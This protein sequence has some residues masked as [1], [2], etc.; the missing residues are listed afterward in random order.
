MAISI[1]FQR[2][3]EKHSS[4]A[5]VYADQLLVSGFN[6]LIGIVIARLLG[7]H[8]YGVYSLAWMGVLIASSFQQAFVII[9]MQT[10]LLKKSGKEKYD[11]AGSLLIQQLVL[12]LAAS[13]LSFVALYVLSHFLHYPDLDTLIWSFPFVVFSYLM[14]DYFRK[15]YLNIGRNSLSILMD[16]IAYCGFTAIV[17]ALS[18]VT[19]LKVSHIFLIMAST[20]LYA[21]LL[22]L[23]KYPSIQLRMPQ[24]N[25]HVKENWR[26]SKWLVA[27]SV[28]QW[29]SG[30]YF[31]LA[32]GSVLG[33]IAVGAVR[34]AQNIV[35]VTHVIFLAMENT[36]PT[37]ASLIF[38][39]NG[40]QALK[41]YLSKFTKRMGLAV[42]LLLVFIGLFASF[43]IKLIYGPEFIMY[44][45]V[46]IG[47]CVVYLFVFIGYP[48]RFALRAME[49]TSSIFFAFVLT[50]IV[51]VI[52]AIPLLNW[53]G[54]MGVIAGLL[55]TQLINFVYYYFRI[56]KSFKEGDEL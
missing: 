10:F 48:M 27:S 11:Y 8:G 5:L 3:Y 26:F 31:I 42:L 22:G 30:N 49:Y 34:M 2:V 15:F 55:L 1:P 17:L 56:K 44:A 54:I 28:L 13:V 4:T 29:F 20:F 38:H 37:R 32:A 51:S 52:I 50:S 43:L 41:K 9:P 19:E 12:S 35:G 45:N 18:F 6:F 47:I 36:V 39:H 53:L 16:G 25:Q 24:F 46:L 21:A 33:P 40:T 23:I 7:I 14:Q